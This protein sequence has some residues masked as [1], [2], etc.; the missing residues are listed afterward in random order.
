[1]VCRDYFFRARERGN[2]SNVGGTQA[3]LCRTASESLKADVHGVAVSSD[4]EAKALLIP[5]S[6]PIRVDGDDVGPNHT[7][8]SGLACRLYSNRTGVPP[9]EVLRVALR[10]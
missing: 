10:T 9:E 2:R 6:L 1:V 3:L 5:G 8:N 7:N 4:A